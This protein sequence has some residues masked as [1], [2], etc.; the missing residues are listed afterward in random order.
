[1]GG[2]AQTLD[3]ADNVPDPEEESAR[4]ALQE[5]FSVTELHVQT[6][7]A[8]A[9]AASERLTAAMAELEVTEQVT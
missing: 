2:V 4:Q 9:N 7:L 8:E 6:K 5:M 3:H 1:M